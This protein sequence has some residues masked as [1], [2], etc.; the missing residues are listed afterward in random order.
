MF[1]NLKDVDKIVNSFAPKDLKESYDN[2]GLMIGD[3]NCCITNILFSLDCTEDVIDEA[4]EKNCNLIF[5]HHPL[6][7][8]KP[9]S[10]TNKTLLGR[11]ILKLIK[12]NVNVYSAHTNLDSTPGGI[13]DLL[14]KLLGYTSYSIIDP[15]ECLVNSSHGAGIGRLVK[16]PGGISLGDLCTNIKNILNCKTIRYCGDENKTVNKLAVIN[17]AG[18]DY[19][20]KSVSLGADCILTGDTTYHYVSDMNEMGIGLIDAGHFNT[21]WPC[22]QVYAHMFEDEIKNK[23]YE[24]EIIISSK[25]K[26]PYKFL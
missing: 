2:V 6:L 24:N 26:S 9:E 5:T 13:N 17:G 10:I 7:F 14:V 21:E 20:H 11:K 3:F 15:I 22:F 19:I 12:N 4:V 16:I 1:L 18:E 8:I 23:G 25:C